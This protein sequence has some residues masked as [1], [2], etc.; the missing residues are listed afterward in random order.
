MTKYEILTDSFEFHFGTSATKIPSFTAD[1][2]FDTYM[3]CDTR[4]TSNSLDPE[5]A[6][7]FDTAE[8]ALAEFRAHYADYG[9]T[10][11][12]K[13]NVI[14]LLCGRLAWVEQNDYNDDGDLIDCYGVL[15]LSAE[16]YEAQKADGLYC[17]AD[18][19]GTLYAHDIQGEKKAELLLSDII[20]DFASRGEPVPD[21]LEVIAQ[22]EEDA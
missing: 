19:S 6:A 3:S 18:D 20:A 1:E 16:P 12:E 9:T 13:G 10:R 11:L 2:I 7:S 17:I 15:A 22:D 21:G 8:E 5:H 4:I 14:Y